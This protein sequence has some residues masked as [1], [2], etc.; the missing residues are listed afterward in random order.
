[1]NGLRSS[2][3][4]TDQAP[5]SAFVKL[6][7][8]VSTLRAALISGALT[9]V[10]VIV[11]LG[12]HLTRIGRWQFFWHETTLTGIVPEQGY[13]F[14]APSGHPTLSG[15]Q[16][17]SPA[18]VLEN[19]VPMG[20]SNAQHED[21]RSLGRGR[22]SFWH[23][24][25]YFSSS[26]LSDPR[27][28][29]RRYTIRYPPVDHLSASVLYVLT[30]VSVL[31]FSATASFAIG[32]RIWLLLR[33]VCS[34]V[35]ADT[36][37]FLRTLRTFDASRADQ[38]G[39][40]LLVPT[41]TV[42]GTATAAYAVY[43]TWRDPVSALNAGRMLAATTIAAGLWGTAGFV[44]ATTR[45]GDGWRR[46][47]RTALEVLLFLGTALIIYIGSALN[48]GT[49]PSI[50]PP[51]P[52]VIVAVFGA[53]LGVA[54]ERGH[55]RAV[56]RS[57]DLF[58]AR[59]RR[60]P[61]AVSIV[62]AVV[63]AVPTI[64]TR[65]LQNWNVSGWR[66]S[67]SYDVYAH[68][69]A[70][71]KVVSGDS[72]Y[73]PVF[74]YG[75]AGLDYVFGHF[76]FVQ[77]LTNVALAFAT[78][79]LLCL[80]AW[81]IFRVPAVVL[82]V[83]LWVAFADSL[84]AYV[85][86]TQIEAWYVPF[87]ALA[88]FLWSCYWRTPSTSHLVL[89]A[90]AAGLG[91][92]TRS[93][94]GAFFAVLCLSPLFVAQLPLRRRVV[95]AS[96]AL[97]ILGLT[98]VPWTIRNWVVDHSLTPSGG[99][100]AYYIA[101]LNDHRIGFYGL[102]YWEGW[103]EIGSEY[104]RK[105]PDPVE[106]QRAMIK[107]GISS[108]L[109]D[110]SWLRRALFWRLLSFYGLAP[111]GIL[112]PDGIRPTHWA[113]EWEGYILYRVTQFF[114]LLLTGAAL[115]AA[116]T[117]TNV[118]LLCAVA[119]NLVIILVSASGEPRLHYP[120]LPLHMLIAASILARPAAVGTD[121]WQLTRTLFSGGRLRYWIAAMTLV[122]FSLALCRLRIGRA[123]LYTPHLE[124][125]VHIDP[126]VR[127][128]SRLPLL[129]DV[130]PLGAVDPTS[131]YP[132]Q[133]LSSRVSYASALTFEHRLVRLRFIVSNY[134]MPPKFLGRV[135]YVPAFATDPNGETFYYAYLLNPHN[136]SETLKPSVGVSLSGSTVS[137][138]LREGDSVDGEGV[139]LLVQPGLIY[140]YWVRLSRIRKLP[141]EHKYL[142]PLYCC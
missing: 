12:V 27:S 15:H 26:D 50:A 22:F 132:E 53:L 61:P 130:L 122:V 102:R 33:R 9:I 49:V 89:M 92:N 47:S 20:A 123:N 117:R 39:M 63:L 100:T 120:V 142:P 108:A 23:Q 78:V 115:V 97:T 118:F 10:L 3:V 64:V 52:F 57:F 1:V 34:R 95:Q 136:P 74:Q 55:A 11:S 60:F 65:V 41:V 104:D 36:R 106:R 4:T 75:M 111:N 103:T 25:V 91:L 85:H 70:S 114:F 77:Q 40:R 128:D 133:V 137:E 30:V 46:L 32:P 80:A 81:N 126:D 88:I 7:G 90:L 82:I 134:M 109:S 83:G 67:H 121:N 14:V 17:R 31:Y 119:A 113:T 38:A 76:F 16:R 105:Y 116:F 62:V 125:A 86:F 99:L 59:W 98:L 94:G 37:E 66:D 56:R 138:P 43:L 127:I 141:F 5:A 13:A 42:V 107:A 131:F 2:G 124:R 6:P 29:G 135:G 28:N 112:A 58:I 18:T 84:F 21:I 71:G 129:N 93:Q 54:V 45:L 68:N 79:I 48:T 87:V 140:P 73:M 72:S 24:Y 44:L 8:A 110:W 35:V 96:A 69:I 19:G 51:F 101:I 139:V